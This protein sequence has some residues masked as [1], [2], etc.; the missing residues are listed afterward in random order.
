MKGYKVFKSDWT[1]R[2]FQYACPGTFEEDVTPSVCNCGFHFCVKAVDCFRYYDF[3]PDNKVAEVIAYGDMDSD[4]I[5]TCTNKIQVVR[6]I[7]WAELLEIVNVGKGCA[8]LGNSG[9][10]NSGNCNSGNYNSGNYNSGDCNN[11]SHNSGDW[12]RG[13]YNSGDWNKTFFSA[14]CFCTEEPKIL[15]FNKPSDWTMRDWL[16]SDARQIL[17]RIPTLGSVE[18]VRFYKMSEQEKADH[19]EAETTHG[20]LKIQDNPECVQIWWNDLNAREKSIV[21]AIPNFDKAIFKEITG[22]DVDE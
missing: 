9:I 11:G 12:N 16:D 19:P 3:D 14:G 13:N 10:F 7:P 2:G 18:Y 1:C 6:E 8:G 17:R 21:K 15:L 5:K 20:Y 4:G 22:I